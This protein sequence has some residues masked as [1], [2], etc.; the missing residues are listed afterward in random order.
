V[1]GDVLVVGGSGFLGSAVVERLRSDG[2]ETVGTYFTTPRPGAEVEF[3]FFTDDPT[4]LPIEACGQVVFAAHVERADQPMEAFEA[5]AGRFVDACDAADARLLYVSSA[6]VFD[7]ERG[8]YT[9]RDTPRP[10]SR[11]GTR[12]RAF[13]RRVRRL[14]DVCILRPDYLFGRSRGE[15]DERL[16]RTAA[17]VRDGGR[18]S[19]Y[20]DMYKSPFAVGQAG[21]AVS[22]LVRSDLQGV[23]HAPTPRTS[24]FAFHRAAAAA[25]GLPYRRIDPEPMPEDPSLHRDTSLDSGRFERALGFRPRSVARSMLTTERSDADDPP[26][27]ESG[28][29]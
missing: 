2:C 26:D 21:R 14:S 22:G 27:G 7:G 15:L 12:L 29:R 13:E 24:V 11:Y 1:S 25:M 18:V 10:K 3:D 8:R 5:A 6:G 16:A 4:H 20:E 19:Y 9:E 23:V 17:V 28:W